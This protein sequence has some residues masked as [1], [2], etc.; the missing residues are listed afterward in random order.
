M[1]NILLRN[2]EISGSAEEIYQKYGC[3]EETP[4]ERVDGKSP[5]PEAPL[6][7]V[8]SMDTA[9]SAERVW[10][11]DI[12]ISDFGEASILPYP[13]SGNGT[14]M[15]A[16]PPEFHLKL[17]E[18]YGQ[19]ADIWTAACTIY[20]ILG[21]V[22]LFSVCEW[23]PAGMMND[24]ARLLGPLP[25]DLMERWKLVLES[26]PDEWGRYLLPPWEGEYPER[27]MEDALAEMS[28]G[29]EGN[30]YTEEELRDLADLLLSMLKYRPSERVTADEAC[31]S[32]WMQ[33]WG[34]PAITRTDG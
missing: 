27:S 11:T 10:C 17:A 19:P 12:M 22:P 34:L 15:H 13:N 26:A 32:A 4:I 29:S 7:T 8:S 1:G 28:Y 30:D 24:I 9:K 14:P 3:P 25:K 2:P 6:Y 16:R 5:R 33:K 20:H 31:Q 21:T 23:N 18:E